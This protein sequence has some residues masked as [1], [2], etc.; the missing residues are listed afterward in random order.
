VVAR[1]KI[2]PGACVTIEQ[3][4]EKEWVRRV[5]RSQKTLGLCRFEGCSEPVCHREWLSEEDVGYYG[6]VKR[7]PTGRVIDRCDRGHVI[8]YKR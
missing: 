7:K 1:E 5:P 6:Q 2:R 4:G 8:E 3:R